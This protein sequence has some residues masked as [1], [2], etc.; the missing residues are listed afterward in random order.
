MVGAPHALSVIR[1][2]SGREVQLKV[3]QCV[4]SGDYPANS[5]PAIHDCFHAHVARAE[6][7]LAALADQDFLVVHDLDLAHAT[8]GQGRVGET[9]ASDAKR[10]Y[11]SEHGR[12]TSEHPALLSEVASAIA[13]EPYPTLLELDLKDWKPW[14]WPRVEELARLLE[15]VKDR[16]TF[17]GGADWNLR[18]LHTVD[19]SL[20]MGFTITDYLDWLPSDRQADAPTR[21]RGAYGYFDAHPLARERYGPT[22][23][24]LRDRLGAILRLVPQ[25]RDAH[26][27]LLA[28]ERM[29][30][31]GLT[32]LADLVHAQGM[33]LD[34]WTL[35]AGTQNWRER[36][37]GALAV[38]ADVI[39]S[40]TPRELARAAVDMEP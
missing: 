38:G 32:D 21:Q 40:E 29:V 27:R 39:T 30:E 24:Y 1:T 9:S 15:P 3:H 2:A 5:L 14:P 20:P 7:D 36:L 23:D 16:V 12:V 35:N 11:L 34:V 10:L 18:R 17:G 8:D 13:A 33:L 4:W 22:A 37:A 25:S 31:D 28:V 6:I 19:S 26:I